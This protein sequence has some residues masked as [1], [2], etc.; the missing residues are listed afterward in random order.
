MLPPYTTT[1]ISNQIP[2][3]EPPPYSSIM[4]N[5]H[6]NQTFTSIENDSN[7]NES[8]SK[9]RTNNPNDTDNNS[10]PNTSDNLISKNNVNKSTDDIA[11]TSNNVVQDSFNDANDLNTNNDNNN[12]KPTD[13][14]NLNDKDCKT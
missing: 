10:N 1:P 13:N 11:I 14:T 5:T 3:N 9:L 7:D 6:L 4:E 2:L 8:I 12:T